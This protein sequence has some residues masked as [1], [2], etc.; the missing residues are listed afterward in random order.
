M[1]IIL[2]IL[3]VVSGIFT[4]AQNSQ[5]GLL[6]LNKPLTADAISQVDAKTSGGGIE[7]SGVSPS[8]ARIEVYIT[9]NGR[10]NT[11]TKEEIQKIISEDYDFSVSVSGNKLTATAR[12]KRSFN[13]WNNQISISYSIFVP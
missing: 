4:E 1:R 11:Y 10:H 12:P 7:V 3:L 6:Y 5:K 9:G 2:S 8:E 13:N